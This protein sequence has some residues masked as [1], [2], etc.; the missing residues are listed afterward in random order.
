MVWEVDKFPDI[1]EI[2]LE[3][4]KP[5]DWNPNI[6]PKKFCE[7]LKKNIKDKGFVSPILVRII[8]GGYEIIDG[9]HRFNILKELGYT[10]IPCVIVEEEDDAQAIMRTIAMWRLRGEANVMEIASLFFDQELDTGEI[11]EYLAYSDGEIEVLE[12]IYKIPSKI[13]D[14][15][16]KLGIDLPDE[17]GNMITLE[18]AL[19]MMQNL[20]VQQSFDKARDDFP[21][22]KSK[23]YLL[24][25]ICKYY[26]GLKEKN[27]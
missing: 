2:P 21:N 16:S 13:I 22:I 5:N 14:P 8:K 20:I 17:R 10:K 27:D 26:V 1:E 19:D 6:L 3:Q 11:K 23:N 12:N 7:A 18:F 4:I 24:V 9:E 25:E 15:F